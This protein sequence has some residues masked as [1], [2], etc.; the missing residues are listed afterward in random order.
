MLNVCVTELKLNVNEV[1]VSKERKAFVDG[2]GIFS[3]LDYFSI[4]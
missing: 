3:I 1:T 2:L 4:S